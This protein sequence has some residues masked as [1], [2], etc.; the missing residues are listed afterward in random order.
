MQSCPPSQSKTPRLCARTC[1]RTR[2]IDQHGGARL[3]GREACP[4]ARARDERVALGDER[5]GWGGCGGKR[6]PGVMQSCS[7]QNCYHRRI[8]SAGEGVAN[9]CPGVAES[10]CSHSH[11][12]IC[13][14]SVG[15]DVATEGSDDRLRKYKE[16]AS[17]FSAVANRTAI[18]WHTR[19]RRLLGTGM[20]PTPPT[21]PLVSVDNEYL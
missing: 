15:E 4:R 12:H 3:A 16:K 17:R 11:C 21:Q 10:Y 19:S 7:S 2:T 1:T 9:W 5:I 20:N 8:E 6:C 18:C 13:I 14:E